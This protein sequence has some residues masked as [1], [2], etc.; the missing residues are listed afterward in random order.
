MWHPK[1]TPLLHWSLGVQKQKRRVQM[2]L[3]KPMLHR[4]NSDRRSQTRTPDQMNLTLQKRQR[5]CCLGISEQTKTT[6]QTSLQLR[7]MMQ[8]RRP[9]RWNSDIPTET[10][11][12]PTS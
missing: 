6:H 11:R 8:G 3:K 4:L 10:M 7:K 1:T 9:I 5:H 12:Q 2:S